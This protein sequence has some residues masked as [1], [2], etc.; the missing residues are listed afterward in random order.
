MVAVM[1]VGF[2]GL[3]IWY[4]NT[5]VAFKV[6]DD[7]LYRQI[8]NGRVG[9]N[10]YDGDGAKII[11]PSRFFSPGWTPIAELKDSD[12]NHIYS[13]VCYPYRS[14]SNAEPVAASFSR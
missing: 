10:C 5:E 3:F 7:I 13:I 4:E 2:W 9:A 12:A 8:K 1:L 6:E 14:V 11:A